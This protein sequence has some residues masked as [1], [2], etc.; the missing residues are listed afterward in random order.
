MLD[1]NVSSK[2]TDIIFDFVYKTQIPS[3]SITTVKDSLST[4]LKYLSS[5]FKQL[6]TNV[7]KK[8]DLENVRIVV[9]MK[10]NDGTNITTVVFTN[11]GIEDSDTTE[12]VVSSSVSETP[13]KVIMI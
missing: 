5:N 3:D 8:L 2:D 7:E 11:K 4:S 9:N 10:T 12:P 13:T 6:V 1:I